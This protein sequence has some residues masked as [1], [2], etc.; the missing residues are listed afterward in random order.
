MTRHFAHI[1]VFHS[2]ALDLLAIQPGESVLDVTL[3]L[4]GHSF[5]F[6]EANAPDGMLIG[7]DADEQNLVRATEYLQEFGDRFR[8]VH[9]N[10]RELPDCL[11]DAAM[12]F[13]VIFADLGLSSP[14]L[15]DTSRGF[16]FKAS[17]PLDMRFD[18][19]HGK[20]AE[21]FLMDTREDDLL[22][23]FHRF[24]EVQS[25]R[26]LVNTILRERKV[27]RIRTS[28]DL[29]RIAES[30]YSYKMPSVLPQIY[31]A[32]RIAV[33]DELGSLSHLLAVLPTLLKPGARCAVISYHSLED[34]LVKQCFRDL[35]MHVKDD[36]TGQIAH[37]AMFSLLTRRPVLCDSTEAAHN[38]RARSAILR[39]IKRAPL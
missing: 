16:T 1:P 26:R 17:A 19:T 34:R 28:D 14:H 24:G 20:T 37:P 6:L 12:Q 5:S 15:D 13:D 32:L 33:N 30:V 38:P 31:Q 27:Q 2:I 35:T 23:I 8:P 4:G 29:N 25:A 3:G 39:A 9:A 21:D 11:P 36:V 10:F 18:R 7:L 22:R